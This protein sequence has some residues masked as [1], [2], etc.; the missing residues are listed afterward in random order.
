MTAPANIRS[1]AGFRSVTLF[2]LNTAGYPIGSLTLEPII[3]Y[4]VS[5]STISGSTVAVPAG[6]AV[7]GSVGYYGLI[8]SGAK[9][10]TI[11][12]PTPRIIPHVGD[13]GVLAL[14]VLPPLEPLTGELTVS[15][16]N[17]PIDKIVS[18]AKLVQ[19]GEK[20]LMGEATN[21]RGFENQVGA[22]AYAAAL[23]TDPNS[24]SFGA[25]QWD[26]RLFPKANV[27]LRETGYGQEANE[28]MYSFTPMYVTSYI[29]G[30]QFTVAIEGFTRAQVIRGNSQYK[31]LLV[32]YLGDGATVSFPLD[33]NRPAVSVDKMS[34]W[35]NG[36][37]QT[38]GITKSASGVVFGT[39]P[40][41]LDV[42]VILYE[43]SA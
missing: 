6:T 23:D 24:A 21:L 41:A 8:H 20:N 1:T 19:I 33:S 16:T 28:R 22:L 32:S 31:P 37:I 26:F 10:L 18:S 38:S 11:T 42:V 43:T 14:Q 7:S 39:A 34:V 12:D 5:G 40:A 13:D 9:M 3:P 25:S 30:T 2:E 36:A 35:K 15:K 4:T 17:D 27:F 29:W